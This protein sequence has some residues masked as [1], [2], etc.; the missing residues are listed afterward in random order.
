MLYILI[1][2][3]SDEGYCWTEGHCNNI[4]SKLC[5]EGTYMYY[6]HL[7]YLCINWDVV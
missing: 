2:S 5:I 7:V 3:E 4:A 1:G 6:I